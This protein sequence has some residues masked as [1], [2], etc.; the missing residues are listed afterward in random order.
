MEEHPKDPQVIVTPVHKMQQSDF[1]KQ[2]RNLRTEIFKLSE[3]NAELR[4]KTRYGRRLFEPRPTYPNDVLGS[5]RSDVVSNDDFLA[6]AAPHDGR[7]RVRE[8]C[9]ES[10]ASNSIRG[11]ADQR[12]DLISDR[13]DGSD[14][15]SVKTSKG[16]ALQGGS[17][18]QLAPI[19]P[20][21]EFKLMMDVPFIFEG[22]TPDIGKGSRSDLKLSRRPHSGMAADKPSK[23]SLAKVDNSDSRSEESKVSGTRPKPVKTV[24]DFSDFQNLLRDLKN[25]LNASIYASFNNDIEE[26]VQLLTSL[27]ERYKTL[28]DRV[29]AT[30]Q[31][32]KTKRSQVRNANDSRSGSMS[33]LSSLNATS[34]S[35]ELDRLRT[36]RKRLSDLRHKSNLHSYEHKLVSIQSNPSELESFL[37]TIKKELAGREQ[38]FADIQRICDQ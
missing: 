21:K 4:R 37:Y 29:E 18:L 13:E 25:S 14:D 33:N 26:N 12:L 2:I 30:Y 23:E 9:L 8:F 28:D 11:R 34:A 10:K 6:D 20:T 31:A 36:T 38:A 7:N 32:V 5:L 22:Q 15:G 1:Q 3:E 24:K 16:G 27:L 35:P 17:K 19:R